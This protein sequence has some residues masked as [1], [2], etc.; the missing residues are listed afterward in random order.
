MPSLLPQLRVDTQGQGSGPNS[1]NQGQGSGPNHVNS[2]Y[3]GFNQ[4]SQNTTQSNTTSISRSSSRSTT[5]TVTPTSNL[6]SPRFM[7]NSNVNRSSDSV[8]YAFGSDKHLQAV[9]SPRRQ[10]SVSQKND[11]PN[12]ETSIEPIQQTDQ[13]AVD[14][15][16]E[17]LEAE[18][19]IAK[20]QAKIAKLRKEK[21]AGSGTNNPGY[22]EINVRQGN[23]DEAVS[24][25]RR[26]GN[27][28]DIGDK[29]EGG[30]KTS[31]NEGTPPWGA[32]GSIS[33]D[34]IELN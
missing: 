25:F 9:T 34:S 20:L 28:E 13:A 19:E 30:R 7:N 21:R 12:S 8:D 10:G 31:I 3:M 22:D 2:P 16:I 4:G 29:E 27:V 1:L 15:E 14:K 33:S 23:Y 11:S 18:L 17:E 26:G 32:V 6:A 24:V 5:G